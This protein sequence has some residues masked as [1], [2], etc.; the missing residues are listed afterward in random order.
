[1]IAKSLHTITVL[2]ALARQ[3]RLVS[4]SGTASAAAQL[5]AALTV[6]GY[7]DEPTDSALYTQAL[8]LISKDIAKE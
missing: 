7:S 8:L 1:M 4:G 5:S 3:I 2:R 6:L